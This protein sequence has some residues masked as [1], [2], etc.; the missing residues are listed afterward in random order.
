MEPGP[1]DERQQ[2]A[3]GGERVGD[4]DAAGGHQRVTAGRL[5]P[6]L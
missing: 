5:R 6:L 3:D 4:E 1:E 2:Q